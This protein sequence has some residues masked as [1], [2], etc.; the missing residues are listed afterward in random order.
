MTFFKVKRTDLL[1]ITLFQRFLKIH[2]PTVRAFGIYTEAIVQPKLRSENH[3]QFKESVSVCV[4]DFEYLL[5][6]GS[7]IMTNISEA[8]TSKTFSVL[9]QTYEMQKYRFT[10]GVQKCEMQ[11][12]CLTTGDDMLFSMQAISVEISFCVF[13]TF[14]S[15]RSHF[16]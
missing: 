14:I 11:K 6:K 12:Y 15:G 5:E 9:V 10:T 1:Q 7:S 13:S 3:Q 4:E 2:H 8:I 16:G